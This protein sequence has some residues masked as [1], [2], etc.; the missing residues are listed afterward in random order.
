MDCCVSYKR[1][2]IVEALPSVVKSQGDSK[3]SISFY[4]S[5]FGS[6]V[7]ICESQYFRGRISCSNRRVLITVASTESNHCEFNFVGTPLEPRSS[8]GKFLRGILQNQRHLFHVAV[9][10]QLQE[11]AADRDE[12]IARMKRSLGSSESSL[13]R[14]I[15]E[16]TE[17]ECRISVEDVMY[18]SIVHKFSEIKVPMVP[19]LSKCNMGGILEIW[20]SKDKELESIHGFEVMEMIR[21]HLAAVLSWRG[22]S[23]VTNNWASTRIHRFQLGRVYAASIMYGYFLK[24]ACLRH[25]LE[26]GLA[27]T[28]QDLPL[29]QGIHLPLPNFCPVGPKNAAVLGC[30]TNIG[31]TSLCEGSKLRHYVM[32]FDPDTLQRCAKLKSREAVN[33]IE[34]H[35]WELFGDEKT[36]SHKTDVVI[37]ITF[38]N[39]KRLVLEAVAFGSF[40][41]D[42]E[43]FVDSIYTLTEN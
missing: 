22:K 41:W 29:G 9:S 37:A 23:N 32:G 20:P 30:S 40:L 6:Q 34:M 35:S 39:M 10:E 33:L 25:H 1:I 4:K 28:H 42:V 18:M 26:L 21:E 14:R 11:L 13:H 27:Q 24:S 15:T 19:M 16:L 43:R 38:P 17:Y 5:S 12:A 8:A 31:S 7:K 3:S 2:P 36:G